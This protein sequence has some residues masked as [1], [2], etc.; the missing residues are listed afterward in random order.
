MSETWRPPPRSNADEQRQ[1]APYLPPPVPAW[2][3][4]AGLSAVYIAIGI[5]DG[6]EAAASHCRKLKR[7][8]GTA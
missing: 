7:T 3:A 2:A 5:R 6:E 1:G 4:R 8:I